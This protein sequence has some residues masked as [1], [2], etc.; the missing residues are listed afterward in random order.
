[1]F[2]LSFQQIMNLLAIGA[3]TLL[4]ALLVELELSAEAK[5]RQLAKLMPYYITLGVIIVFTAAV[6][7]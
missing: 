3:T 1:M 5:K 7:K 6:H 2:T 4:I